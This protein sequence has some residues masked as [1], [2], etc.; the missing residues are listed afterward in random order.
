MKET[1][2]LILGADLRRETTETA[3]KSATVMLRSRCRVFPKGLWVK[4]SPNDTKV[5]AGLKRT[6]LH[7][8]IHHKHIEKN[9][10]NCGPMEEVQDRSPG[11]KVHM[12][13]PAHSATS[14]Q[15]LTTSHQREEKRRDF[16]PVQHTVV[17]MRI[18][19]MHTTLQSLQVCTDITKESDPLQAQ[20]V[21][22]DPQAMADIA[23]MNKERLP[24][25]PTVFRDDQEVPTEG[26]QVQAQAKGKQV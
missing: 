14:P 23:H 7:T 9:A 22:G 11:Q 8:G 20:A 16:P 10:K 18:H 2:K 13:R 17:E 3:Q 15:A 19:M 5:K 21:G 6:P 25:V 24:L 4:V 26:L 1:P 12:G